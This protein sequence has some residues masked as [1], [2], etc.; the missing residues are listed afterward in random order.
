MDER[1]PE[2][3]EKCLVGLNAITREAWDTAKQTEDKRER[4]R[5]YK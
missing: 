4:Y 1:R 5:L 3:Y 2:E